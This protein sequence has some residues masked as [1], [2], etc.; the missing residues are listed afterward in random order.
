MQRR[1]SQP[2]FVIL[3]ALLSATVA[4]SIDAMLPGL[5][6]IAQELTPDNINR[7]QLVLTSF[8]LGMGIGTF[9]TGPISDR[10][11]RKPVI[12]VGLALY[13]L[14]A[15]V[16]A[17]AQN[18][19]VL[20]AARVAQGIAAAGPRVATLAMLRDTYKGREMARISSYMMT[21]F[22]LVP[23]VAP[24]MGQAIMLG[25]G[26]RGIFGAFVLFA[27]M[28]ALWLG[29]R[30]PETLPADKRVPLERK[31]II[32]GLSEI[33]RNRLVMIYILVISFGFGQ[34][35][36]LISSIQQ[37]YG[38]IFGRLDSFPAWFAGAA[39]FSVSGTIA[40]AM[41]VKRLGMRHI[42][43]LAYLGQIVVSA[44]LIIV[45]A[46]DVLPTSLAFPA[47]FLWT[48]SAFA[49]AGLTFGNLM[50]LALEPLGR[51][52]GLGASVVNGASTV[53][54]VIIAAPIGLA[55]NGT[56]IPLLIGTLICSTSALLLLRTATDTG[57]TT[58]QAP[59]S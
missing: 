6:R 52:A 11:G 47:F 48:I 15:V 10:F 36:G 28:N 2:E 16:A 20:L 58:D 34:L 37:I 9:F 46:L 27:L 55:F 5:P 51:I 23:A 54:A 38:D 35:F 45:T 59:E 43:R 29:I 53:L 12:I 50:A 24:A 30:Q 7:A 21:V 56:T 25:F 41:L 22:T 42:A 33:M 17:L 49:M 32:A 8:V 26:W 13:M 40:N 19:E 4:L 18:F 1:L 3:L 57:P 14:A 31:E 39:L 44:I